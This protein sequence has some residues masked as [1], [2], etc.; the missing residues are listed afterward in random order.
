VRIIIAAGLATPSVFTAA[1][2]LAAVLGWFAAIGAAAA[3]PPEDLKACVETASRCRE[4]C[5]GKASCEAACQKSF[6]QCKLW[7][8]ETRPN[9]PR[10]SVMPR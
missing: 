2:G 3:A 6:K 8:T 5:Q 9:H 7:D 10:D 1:L 4:R